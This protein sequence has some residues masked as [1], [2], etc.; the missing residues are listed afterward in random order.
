MGAYQWSAKA[1]MNPYQSPAAIDEQ[2]DWNMSAVVNAV[3]LTLL[4]ILFFPVLC[5]MAG[6]N[7]MT[8]PT[9]WKDSMLCWLAIVGGVALWLLWVAVFFQS[10]GWKLFPL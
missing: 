7:L 2:D 5:V 8:H 6:I 10:I 4:V 9:S 3:V 1:V